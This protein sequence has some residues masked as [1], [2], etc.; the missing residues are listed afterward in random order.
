MIN[1]TI[2]IPHK[3]ILQLLQRCLDSIPRRE[4]IQIIVVDDN[5]DAEQVDFANFPG[6]NNPYVEVI[7]GKNEAGRKGAGYA[8]NLGLEKAKGKWVIFAD[9]DDFFM[10]C[11]S[12][13]LEKYKDNENDIVFFKATSVD[14][15]T[16]APTFSNRHYHVNFPL[17]EIQQ[18][19]NWDIA[20]QI[21]VPWG[22]FIKRALI[23]Q[24]HI[25]FQ[26]VPC[27]ND[28]LFSVKATTASAKKTISDDVIYCITYR[29]ESLTGNRSV[30]ILQFR[31]GIYEDVVC[32]LKPLKK[33][34]LIARDIFRLWLEMFSINKKTAL[35]LLPRMIQMCGINAFWTYRKYMHYD[36][37]NS[38]VWRGL[39]KMK[40]LIYK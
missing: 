33:E 16:L 26:E 10:P 2:I 29:N 15:D 14:S 12:D 9:A 8:R 39:R 6:L 27:S 37:R 28:I 32:Y 1:Y 20:V 21:Y 7:F 25:R 22:K 4:D 40:R 30:H 35:K 19:N 23:E 34:K 38:Y 3:N 36:Y 18:T 11:F 24:N 31:L 17:E 13:A 5:S